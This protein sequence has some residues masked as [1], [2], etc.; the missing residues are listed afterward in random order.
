[1]MDFADEKS[2]LMN[3]LKELQTQAVQ[4]DT[5]LQQVR[6][7][8]AKTVGAL[9]FLGRMEQRMAVVDARVPAGQ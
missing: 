2:I 6:Q 4:L 8:I 9:E 7:E 5:A 1:M 3:R